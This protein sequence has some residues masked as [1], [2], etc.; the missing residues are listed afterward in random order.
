MFDLLFV[1][2]FAL[3]ILVPTFILNLRQHQRR[4]ER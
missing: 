4:P 2:V 3:N 1:I